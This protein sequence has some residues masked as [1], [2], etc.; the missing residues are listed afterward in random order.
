VQ[1]SLSNALTLWRRRP[2]GGGAL[3]AVAP[4]RRR[5]P[6][7]GGALAAAPPWRRRRSGG[8]GALAAAAPWS[9]LWHKQSTDASFDWDKGQARSSPHT[10]NC[11]HAHTSMHISA[12][13]R[14]HPHQRPHLHESFFLHAHSHL[15]D[16]HVRSPQPVHVSPHAQ[17]HSIVFACTC[18]STCTYTFTCPFAATSFA[19]FPLQLLSNKHAHCH[20]RQ[21]LFRNNFH[22]YKPI[23]TSSTNTHAITIFIHIAQHLLVVYIYI[24]NNDPDFVPTYVALFC[25]SCV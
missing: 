24:S 17:Q 9:K 12:K 3:V 6:G 20:F 8:G 4:W 23:R 22:I 16:I 7:G 14:L 11:S 19:T 21:H 1:C 10:F 15:L 18:R 25:F 13:P 5:R 2:G